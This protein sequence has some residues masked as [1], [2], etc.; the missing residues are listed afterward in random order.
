MPRGNSNFNPYRQANKRFKGNFY[1]KR[2]A[3]EILDATVNDNNFVPLITNS[4]DEEE[5]PHNSENNI[6]RNDNSVNYINYNNYHNDDEPYR[7][8]HAYINNPFHYWDTYFCDEGLVF[9]SCI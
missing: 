5:F 4:D 6:I 8:R 9:M 2:N 1:T 7:G 3:G